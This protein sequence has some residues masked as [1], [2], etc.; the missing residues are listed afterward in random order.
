MEQMADKHLHGQVW[1]GGG[2]ECYIY[3]WCLF[4]G[5]INTTSKHVSMQGRH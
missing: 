1:P 4:I 5:T 3:I 2:S